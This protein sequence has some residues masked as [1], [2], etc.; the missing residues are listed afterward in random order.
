M[1]HVNILNE[2]RG[3]GRRIPIESCVYECIIMLYS[4]L[5]YISKTE[6]KEYLR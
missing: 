2:L 3:R 1:I 4:H 5:V 6:R